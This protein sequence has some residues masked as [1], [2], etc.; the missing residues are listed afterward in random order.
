MKHIFYKYQG[1]GNDFIIL[2]NRDLSFPKNDTKLIKFLCDR[3]FGIGAD[4]LMLLESDKST[5]FKM[6]YY[7]ADGN[8]S[9]MCGNGGRCLVAFA[10]K[11]GVIQDVTTF[12]AVDGIHHARITEENLVSLQ[13]IDVASVK[14]QSGYVFLNTGSPHHVQE[15]E[16]LKELEVK[17]EGAKIRYSDLYGQEGSNINFVIQKGENSFAIRTYERG[18]EDETLS[19]GTGAT[20]VA[21]AMYHLGKATS[22]SI[23]IQVE[24]GQLQIA[25]QKSEN[26]Y[27]NIQLT[28]AAQFVF[29]GEISV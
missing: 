25:F 4:G 8:E 2:D 1:T 13:M 27:K 21:L 9:S 6:V 22:N 15:V 14:V 17:K 19:C 3:R 20:A 10:K 24:G 26:G 18:V 28:G 12:V 11:I 23:A 7:N 16:D 5:D 29:Q